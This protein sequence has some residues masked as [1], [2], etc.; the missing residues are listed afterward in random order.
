MCRLL[1]T[2]KKLYTSVKSQGTDNTLKCFA[3][4]RSNPKILNGGSIVAD[5]CDDTTTNVTDHLPK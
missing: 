5:L 3:H 1:T 2:K 4:N